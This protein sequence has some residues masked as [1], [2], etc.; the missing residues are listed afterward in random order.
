MS[1]K[2]N[3]YGAELEKVIAKIVNQNPHRVTKTFFKK[4]ITYSNE[5]NT[6]P[7]F[8]FSDIKPNIILG[9]TSQDLGE[10]GI[11]NGFNLLETALPYQNSLTK[12]HQLIELDI[13]SS[14]KALSSEHATLINMS[15]HPL[16]KLNLQS[17]KKMVAPK[18]VYPYIWFR[19]WNHAIGINAKAQN[20]PTTGVDVYQAAQAASAIIGAGA[21]FIALFANSP[22]E[23]GKL[24]KYKE[25]RLKIWDGMMKNSKVEGDRITATFPKSPFKNL[26]QYFEWMFGDKTGI[27]FV[28]AEKNNNKMD[29]KGVGDRILIVENNPAVLTFLSK[30][31]W[32][33]LYLKDI[34]K[35]KKQTVIV[36]PN[37][38][39]MEAMQFA[40]FAGARIRYSLNQKDFP[41]EKFLEACKKTNKNEVEKI[42]EKFAKYMYIEGRDPGSNFPD[43]EIAN[44]GDTIA[45]SVAISPS[46][47]QAG[48]I[49]NLEKTLNYLNKYPWKQLG[50]LRESAIEHGLQGFVRNL[51]VEDFTR[52]ILYLAN[53]GLS[54]DEQWMLS[55]PNWVLLKKQNGADRAISFIK[56]Y[57]GDKNR[58]IKKLIELRKVTIS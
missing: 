28:L 24:S 12:L 6:K 23:E 38:T 11:D 55:Y 56:K 19:G 40:Q 2:I 57:K 50:E 25:S 30:K 46:A 36:Q 22:F 34:K 32:K 4:L 51:R 37:I 20:S 13:R 27:H 10:Q 58:A 49:N 14:Q 1:K 35:K 41:L 21:A 26:A 33:A 52:N 18:G 48:L 29:Y 47:L 44:A 42:F 16:G 9:V 3:T 45:K 15:N 5:R 31:E 39:H 53:E 54:K 7:S 43:K 8:H 17:Y